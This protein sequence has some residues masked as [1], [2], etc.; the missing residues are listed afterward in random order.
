MT[1]PQYEPGSFRDRNARVFAHEGKILRGL[2]PQALAEWEKL[3]A[4]RFFRR[5]ER[6]GTLVHTERVDAAAPLPPG[7]ASWSAILSHQKVPFVSYPYEWCFGMLKDA[8][9]LQLE[10]LLAALDEGMILKDSSAFNVQWNGALPV[11][12]DVASFETQRSGEPWVGYRQFCQ[13]FL[14]PLLVQAYRNVPFQPWLRG[15]LDGIEPEHCNALMSARDYLRAGVLTHVYLQAKAQSHFGFTKRDIRVDL[16]NAG[17]GAEL[18]KANARGLRKIVRGLTWMRDRSTWSEYATE[19]SYGQADAEKKAS[20]VRS[21]VM[22]RP[23]QLVWDLGCNTGRFSRIAA[24]NAQCVVALDGDQLAIERLYQALKLE[25]NTT[26]LPLVGNV[27]DPSPN[28]GWRGT[29][30]R[31]LAERGRPELVLCLALIHHIVIGANIP[32]GEFVN[33]LAA[34]GGDVILEF[35]TKQDPMVQGLLRNKEDNYAD[36][37]QGCLE[38]CLSSSFTI[39]RRETLGSGTRIM[40]HAAAERRF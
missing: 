18:I 16:R 19:N 10:L 38:R 9:L 39:V 17:F 25:K 30:R 20:F 7:L 23:L 28:L 4:T 32:L 35:V 29:E 34:L 1:E 12:I 6:E 26:V 37:E 11:F 8:A 15:S 5:F 40:Y 14:Y 2:N 3:S 21:V 13:M 24:E 36:Y 22:S 27:A 31:S 33:W